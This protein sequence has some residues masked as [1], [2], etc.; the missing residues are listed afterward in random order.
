MR[1]VSG[2]S[3]SPLHLNVVSLP[4][5]GLVSSITERSFC[6]LLAV[7]GMVLG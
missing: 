6:D 1:H 3:K 7:R 4:I 2:S 5:K